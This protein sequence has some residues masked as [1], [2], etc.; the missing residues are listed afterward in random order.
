[1]KM[2]MWPRQLYSSYEMIAT[3]CIYSVYDNNDNDNSDD[4][5]DDDDDDYDSHLYTKYGIK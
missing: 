3:T 2:T 4:D 1:M 5:D